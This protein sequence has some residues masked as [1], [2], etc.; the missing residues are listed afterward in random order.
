[1]SQSPSQR[2]RRGARPRR[3]LAAWFRNVFGRAGLPVPTVTARDEALSL[4]FSLG[5]EPIEVQLVPRGAGGPCYAQTK[6]YRLSY[7]GEGGLSP[8]AQRVMEG[9]VALLRRIEHRLPMRLGLLA[10]A[11]ETPRGDGPPLESTFPFV[12]VEHWRRPEGILHELLVR[13]TSRCNQRCAFCS[14]PIAAQDPT[15]EE[16]RACLLRAASLMPGAEVVLTGGEPLL[17]EDLAEITRIALEHQAFSRVYL[18]TNAVYSGRAEGVPASD[19]LRFFV[20]LHGVTDETYDRCTGT[21]GQ[22]KAA[23]T[24][25]ER[26]QA[27]GHPV[28]LNCVASRLNVE[29]LE[30]VVRTAEGLR[31][32]G[33]FECLHFSILMCPDHRPEAEE[34]L[35]PYSVVAPRLMR[36]WELAQSL[37]VPVAPLVSSTHASIPACLVGP[38]HRRASRVWPEHRQGETGLPEAGHPWVH[39]PGCRQCAAF[40]GCLGVPRPYYL[41]FGLGELCPIGVSEG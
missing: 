22:L 31:R 35:A 24:G 36:A 30:A 9:T 14:G 8:E 12:T 41:R 38:A 5:A 2:P 20:S 1:M 40:C 28:I 27:W 25:I 19:R 29:E 11:E 13:L 15:L 18:Q 7:R 21:S 34:L 17:R 3:G 4:W 10:D 16:I 39:S 23:L 37:G 26:L 33:P 6:R 32:R